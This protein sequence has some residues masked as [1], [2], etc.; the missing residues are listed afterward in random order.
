MLSNVAKYCQMLRKLWNVSK[1]CEM[2]QNVAKC[3]A[4]SSEICESCKMLS[5]VA[6]VAKVVKCHEMTGNCDK[7]QRPEWYWKKHFMTK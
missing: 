2:F 1:C 3:C 4:K 5:N 7:N 6:K